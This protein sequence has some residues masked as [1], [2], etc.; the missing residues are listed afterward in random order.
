MVLFVGQSMSMTRLRVRLH[1][2]QFYLQEPI[3][4]QMIS[5][6][7]LTVNI[8]GA[9]LDKNTN[10]QGCFDL[11]LEGSMSHINSCLTYLESLNLKILGK[12]SPD[13]DSWHC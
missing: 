5:R 1:I 2:P 3:I 11:E 12:S 13:G 8:T 4:S 6:Y 9:E 10:E 7:Q